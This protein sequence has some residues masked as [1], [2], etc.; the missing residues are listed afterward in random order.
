LHMDASAQEHFTEP[1]TGSRYSFIMFKI[2]L[3]K[4]VKEKY[5]TWGF[6]ELND[7]LGDYDD[8]DSNHKLD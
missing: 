3:K 2:K 5:Q 4:P 8:A 7:A 6:K 1:W